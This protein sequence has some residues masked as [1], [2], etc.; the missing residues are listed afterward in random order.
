MGKPLSLDE[1]HG[2]DGLNSN[3]SSQIR[4]S[5]YRPSRRCSLSSDAT[6]WRKLSQRHS[7]RAPRSVVVLYS[8]DLLSR[9]SV[10][11]CGTG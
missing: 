9:G 6:S 4:T 11:S 5:T 7:R 2:P 10:H 8:L 1:V 3:R